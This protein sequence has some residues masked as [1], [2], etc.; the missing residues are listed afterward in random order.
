M[1]ETS[2]SKCWFEFLCS[3]SVAVYRVAHSGQFHTQGPGGADMVVS[4][5]FLDKTHVYNAAFKQN[6]FFGAVE[7]AVRRRQAHTRRRVV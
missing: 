3:F 4:S 6:V 5:T 7:R 2:E 1:C